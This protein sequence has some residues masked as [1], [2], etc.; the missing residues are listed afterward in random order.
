MGEQVLIIG[1]GI[2]GLSTALALGPTGREITILDRDPPPPETSA[3]EAF[4]Q[5]E[6]K[7]V[8]HLRHSHAFLARL[9][10]LIRDNYPDLMKDLLDAGC[11]EI[12]FA[13]N[14]PPKLRHLYKPV[15][16]DDDL[17]I[18]TSRR[19][20]LELVMRRYVARQ[21]HIHFHTPTR[22]RGLITERSAGSLRVRGV[23]AEDDDTGRREI[24]ADIVVDA[25]GKNSLGIDWLREKGAAIN[26]VAAPAGIVYFTRH[27]R[28][29]DGVEPPERGDAPGAADMRYIK[30]GLFP[31]DNR[32]FSI[33]LAVPE[34]EMEIRR[35]IVKPETFDAICAEIPGIAK[36]TAAETS[37]PKGRVYGMGE[38]VSRWR[39]MIKDGKPVALNYFPIG[40]GLIR[41][42]PLY[43][44]GCS[45]AAVS[46][47][48]LR[49]VLEE[50]R[51]AAERAVKYHAKVDAELR[52]YYDTM[53]QQDMAAIRT[54]KNALDPD[55]KPGL[56]A[57]LIGSFVED[58]MMTAIRSDMQLMRAFMRGFHMIEHPSLWLKNP[59]NF[60]KVL[61]IW[62]K[63]KKRNAAF[64]PPKLGPG[65]REMLSKLG[66]SPTADFERLKTAA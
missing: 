22:V 45:F 62:A 38:L 4:E 9:H 18:L 39:Y 59:W 17:T 42:N 46:A 43:G 25:G 48:I 20:T 14:I 56:K 37:E 8:G 61:F 15:P 10:K 32:C 41:T 35:C 2:A 54:A 50:T 55:Y 65:R 34:T 28:L 40:D 5:W 7:G 3:D 52:P 6:R 12:G 44:R 31:A 1:A 13:E 58:G 47:H 66:L 49:D 16:E 64:Y 23:I 63:G 21:P 29:R 30:Y 19:T 57:R 24:F 53:V 11:V 51:D 60:A 33:T 27:Y 26:E 36:W